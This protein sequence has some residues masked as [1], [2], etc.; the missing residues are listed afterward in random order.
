VRAVTSSYLETMGIPLLQGRFLSNADE[1][2]NVTVVNDTLA[3]RF[4]P[5]GGEIGRQIQIGQ[6]SY[7]I[8][9]VVAD[10]RHK[11]LDATPTV[12]AYVPQ[13]T[14]SSSSLRHLTFLVRTT[15]DPELLARTVT[16]EAADVDPEQPL[17]DVGPMENVVAESVAQPRFRTCPCCRIKSSRRRRSLISDRQEVWLRSNSGLS[18]PRPKF[19]MELAR[20]RPCRS[21]L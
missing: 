10:V 17:F 4:W 5:D 16:R 6:T 9:G 13:A 14:R 7:T 12:E 11:G 21:T 19:R 3:R 2:Q 15:Q 8:V 20:W 1:A 18:R